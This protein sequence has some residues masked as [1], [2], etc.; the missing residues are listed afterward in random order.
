MNGFCMDQLLVRSDVLT[1]QKKALLF[2]N[3]VS[4]GVFLGK[5]IR[6]TLDTKMIR[7]HW[8]KFDDGIFLPLSCT[9]LMNQNVLQ[10]YPLFFFVKEKHRSCIFQKKFC[11][12]YFV[13]EL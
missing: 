7:H 6:L 2:R 10:L 9:N 12:F 8:Q 4:I 1:N 3:K 5:V 11:V 13:D